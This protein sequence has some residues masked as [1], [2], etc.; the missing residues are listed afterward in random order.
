LKQYRD[1]ECQLLDIA[2][3]A[4]AK[5]QKTNEARDPE[6]REINKGLRRVLGE[7]QEQEEV[8]RAHESKKAAS[9]SRSRSKKRS[10]K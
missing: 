4:Y 1:T 8:K 9:R 10:A 7:R 2:H 6:V 3:A 5:L